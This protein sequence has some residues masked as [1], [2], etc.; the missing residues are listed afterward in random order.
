MNAKST[1]VCMFAARFCAYLVFLILTTGV[2]SATTTTVAAGSGTLSF[3][4]TG[5]VEISTCENHLEQVVEVVQYKFSAF[6]YTASSGTTT[7]LA[8]S[9]AYTFEEGLGGNTCPT[10]GGPALTWTVSPSLDE[11][12]TIVFTPTVNTGTT[13]VNSV[14]SGYLNPKYIIMGVTYAPPGGANSSVSYADTNFVGNTTTLSSGFSQNYTFK[15]SICGQI[16]GTCGMGGGGLSAASAGAMITGSESNSWTFASNT[17]N[18]VTIS[19][20]TTLTDKT[21]GVPNVYSPV[22]HDY[23]IIWLWLNPITFFTVP[24]TNSLSSPSGTLF[25][26]GFGYD[27]N[28]PLHE[29][30]VWPIYVG[31]LN[32]DFGTF[33]C[34]GV[35]GTIDCQDADALA[36]SWVTTQTFAPGQGPGITPADYPAILGADPFA[37]NPSYVVTL[38]SGTNPPT[39]TD[40]RF[41][42]AGVNGVSP[43]TFPY[44]QAPPDSTTGINETYANQYVNSSA[45]TQGLTYTYAQGFGLEEKFGASFL[46]AS[47]QYDISQN[48]TFTWTD[49][50]QNII[51]NT[52]TQ[53]D[54][55]SIT[56]PACPAPTA[57]CIP[58]Y[59]EPHEFAVYQD[60]MYGS[61]MLWPNPYFSISVTPAAQTVQAGGR[62]TYTIPTAAN[63]GYTGN[64]TSFSITGL[65]SGATGTFSPTTGAAGIT[66]TLTVSTTSATP[67]G[68]YP[69]TISATD[70]SS[71]EFACVS[72]C[73]SSQPY[74]TLVV[75]A[76]PSFSISASPSSRTI[77]TGSTTY[78]VTTTAANGFTEVVDLG[79]DGLPSGS[80]W[81]F[82]PETI[83]G[84]GSS[85][86]TIT[87]TSST[88]KGTYRL[89]ITGTS[90]SL[91]E[92]T[93]VTLIVTGA[94]FTL[95]ATPEG[96]S[97]TAGGSAVYTVSTTAVN[98]FDSSVKL[99][100]SGLPSGATAKFSP[101]SITGAGSSKLTITT[102]SSTP[103][104]D[105]NLTITGTGGTL[106]QTTLIALEVN[107]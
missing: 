104:G 90:G 77:G 39:T 102:T 83:T 33:T 64:L 26:N 36:R 87:T 78:T 21:P 71:T 67:A 68:T 70:G 88:T 15:I 42:Q 49:S 37:K 44:K 58:Q 11:F 51:T 30:D 99:S 76:V 23:D 95:S 75:S 20:Q 100:V 47:V 56:G 80:S 57:P 7:T 96:Q 89:T 82:G 10:P 55:L 40:E 16:G 84:S 69:L 98:G 46:W 13:T 93:T 31:Y 25:F 38:A 91:S 4:V 27:W 66:S 52:T 92:S 65:P 5:P 45:V 12:T 79:V 2:A 9:T 62:A 105:F 61:F 14:Y 29:V 86:L 28:D 63:A 48:W 53:T 43:G 1:S 85:T 74:A 19:K 24:S 3:T 60:N 94:T 35:I 32:G 22:D 107:N 18:T 101:T 41:S 59:T 17:A 54:T 34:N 81:T 106:T 73:S 103:A 72:A 50:W 97:I 8:G 6:S